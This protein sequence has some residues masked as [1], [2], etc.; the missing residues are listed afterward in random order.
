MYV[1][2]YVCVYM[3]VCMY[4]CMYVLSIEPI[5]SKKQL[6]CVMGRFAGL[7]CLSEFVLTIVIMASGAC[8][9]RLRPG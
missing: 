2:M 9:G 4:A 8:P 6:S 3:Y 5:K 1:C 7:Y